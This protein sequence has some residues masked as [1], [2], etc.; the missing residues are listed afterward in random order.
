R[1]DRRRRRNPARRDGGE[2]H[3]AGSDLSRGERARGG[4]GGGGAAAGAPFPHR[5]D[6]S[7]SRDSG[8][9]PAP[10]GAG[11]G[12]GRR[13]RPARGQGTGGRQ[14]GAGDRRR[15]GA[16]S[17]V[18]GSAGFGQVD[19]GGAPAGPVAAADAAGA[20]G[21]LDGLVGGG[22]DRA[23]RPDARAAVPGDRK[24]TR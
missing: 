8:A 12:G 13:A 7:F 21:D 23:R 16:Q 17:A 14:A 9:A 3:G 6:Q 2:R 1:S 10:A 11:G 4:V 18:R 22:A 24:S 15:R 19:D 20:A 5:P